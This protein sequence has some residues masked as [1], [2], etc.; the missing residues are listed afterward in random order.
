VTRR[1][2]IALLAVV[3]GCISV[4]LT[5][6]K[7]GKIGALSCSIG[8]CETV[9][10]SKWSFFLGVPVAEWGLGFYVVLLAIAIAGTQPR[11][12]DSRAVSA[13]LLALATAGVLFS[14]YLT[15]LELFVIHAI[16][17]WCVGSAIVVTVI[18]VIAVIEYRAAPLPATPSA[19]PA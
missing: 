2:L 3:G 7:L 13:T 17:I 14:A 8:S 11:L 6:Y 15:S 5:L 19:R 1:Q 10:T 9:N 4:Y 16:C 12:E 18:F